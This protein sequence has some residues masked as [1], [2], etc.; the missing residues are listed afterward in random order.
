MSSGDRRTALTIREM[1]RS[2]R[3]RERLKALGA[4]A[5]S[6]AELLALLLGSGSRR[7]SALGIGQEILAASAGSLRR[8]ASRPVAALTALD[9]VGVARAIAIHAALELGRRMAAE[10]R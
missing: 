6:S 8:V 2:E 4:Q 10:A 7:R 5:L 9:G 1:P 3:P